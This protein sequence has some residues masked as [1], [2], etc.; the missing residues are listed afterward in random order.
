MQAEDVLE[1]RQALILAY[2]HP[3]VGGEGRSPVLMFRRLEDLEALVQAPDRVAAALGLYEAVARGEAPDGVVSKEPERFVHI[4]EDFY[5]LP[6]VDHELAELGGDEVRLLRL[7]AAVPGSRAAP[8]DPD[9][10]E[11]PRYR[12]EALTPP[13]SGAAAALGVDLVF[14]MDL[15]LSM[16]PYIDRTKEA[17]SA[18]ARRL[19]EEGVE[20]SLRLGLVG[21]RDDVAK[22]PE[23]EFTARNFT[24]ELV[25]LPTFV[26]ILDGEA[27]AATRSSPGYAEEVFAGVDLGLAS[28]WRPGSLRFICLVGD[29]SSHPEG[30]PQSTTGKNA[31]VLRQAAE[32]GEVHV[33]AIQLLN[34]AHPQDQPLARDQFGTLAQVRGA[35]GETALV[36]VDT[37]DQVDFRDAV[38]RVSERMADVIAAARAGELTAAAED[39]P[40]Q[41][42]GDDA[43]AQADRAAQAVI[44]AALV[45]YLGREA[46][47]PKDILVWAADRDLLNPAVH[48]LEVRVLV[49]REQL[50]SLVQALDQVLTALSR[51]AVT[52]G[53]FFTAL[54]EVAGQTLKRPDAIREATTLG[55]TGLLPS[56]ILSLPYHS[57]VLALNDE[58]YASMTAD[59]R[60]ALLSGL[61]AK[62]RQYR[63]INEQV[64]AWVRLD[65]EDPE[66]DRVYPLH[67]DYLP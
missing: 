29:A 40:P 17:V 26:R 66:S 32:D 3:G 22:A 10:L 49:T 9:L 59:Q 56:F 6:I 5:I 65:E 13:A 67:L 7:A 46:E 64:D 60:A 47:P 36:Q 11:N 14:V 18:I 30:H 53:Q 24:P 34:P 54:Q 39:L 51:S 21:F 48:S 62:L 15:T 58:I 45:E 44:R 42:A 33:I 27:R 57:E 20:S 61:R 12:R 16:Q 50:S 19:S 38:Q 52:Q 8:D 1:W 31:F 37:R 35:A 63:T 4:T 23:L 2:T 55:E 43:V 25:D 41:P 28:R